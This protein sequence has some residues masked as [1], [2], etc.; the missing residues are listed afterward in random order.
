MAP[1]QL[2]GRVVNKATGQPVVADLFYLPADDN[3][4]V[5]DL[6]PTR[7]RLTRGRTDRDGRFFIELHG[8]GT[9]EWSP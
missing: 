5:K 4:N 9:G 7:A 2:T 6:P 3:P 1:G 8:S